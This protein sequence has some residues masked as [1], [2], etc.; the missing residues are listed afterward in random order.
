MATFRDVRRRTLLL[1]VL[2]IALPSVLL[3]YLALRGIR[4]DQALLERAR[5]EDLRRI[6]SITV[7]AHDSD[8]VAAGRALDSTLA[9]AESMGEVA[10][11]FLTE[12]TARHPLIEAVFGLSSDGVIDEFVSP[13]VLFH[14]SDERAVSVELPLAGAELTRLEV[15]RRLELREGKPTEALAAYSRLVSDRSDARVRAEALGGI[16]RIHRHDGDFDEAANSYRRLEA[17]FG[18][19]L[20]G[21]GISFGIVAQLELGHTQA[22]AGDTAGAVQT[23][24]ELYA[25]LVRTER[26]LS[27]AQFSFIVDRLRETVDGLLVDSSSAPM[28]AIGDTVRT[29]SQEEDLARAGTER[30][31]TFQTSAGA[32]LLARQTRRSENS[33]MRYGRMTIELQGQAFYLMVPQQ[34]SESA[35]EAGAWGL[36][37]DPEIME[38]RLVSALATETAAEQVRWALRG[39]A[40]DV[41]H[42]SGDL[43]AGVPAVSVGLPEGVPPFTIELFPP[44]AGF[45]QTLLTSPRGVFFYAFL[46]LAGILIFGLALTLSTVSH[47]L[48]LAR[49]QSDFVSTVSHEFK[50]PLTAVRQIAEMLQADK[51]PSDEKRRRYYDVLVEQSER[52]SLLINRV[53]NFARMDS[54]LHTFDVRPVDVSQF[55]HTLV[56]E[57]QQRVSDDGFVVR[58]E[59]EPA[60]PKVA[61]EPD[62]FGQAVTNLIENGI[63]YSGDSK[64]IVVRGFAENG[65]I[66]IAVQDFGIG[67]DPKEKVRVFERFYRGGDALT[68][69]VKGTGLG[70]TLVK[71]IVEGHGGRVDADSEPGRGSTFYIRLPPE[72]TTI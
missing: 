53:L 3:G 61:L 33:G 15:A 10:G 42:A 20:T 46:L 59:I 45:V 26:G 29:L 35:D 1:F 24:V 13:D 17:E 22:L 34:R 63:K 30:L 23:L 7:A 58:G 25:H 39:S 36:L 5:R 56:S 9:H 71:Q 67:L 14:A 31:L 48:E 40:G 38:A 21:G 62:A 27:R 16:A 32:A 65:D 60:L 57:V 54:G 51:V 69:S 64:E 18:R 12:L 68:R 70:L 4:N 37:L 19:V 47:Q 66:V 50:S 8:L 49:M 2:G 44:E 6:A 28:A 52:L 55:L 41:R 72:A 43:D 11:P